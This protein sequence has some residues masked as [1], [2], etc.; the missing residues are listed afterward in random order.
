MDLSSIDVTSHN[1]SKEY[2]N[3]KVF[4]QRSD[5]MSFY[6]TLSYT[7]MGFVS[8]GVIGIIILNTGCVVD[9]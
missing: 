4:S 8:S 5:F 7:T 3:H 1:L 2:T 6:D 9:L